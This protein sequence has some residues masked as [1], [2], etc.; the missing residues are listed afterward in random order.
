MLRSI[1]LKE[2]TWL[3]NSRKLIHRCTCLSSKTV[4]K[5]YMAAHW[6]KWCI[7]PIDT[8]QASTATEWT[9]EPKIHSKNRTIC[10]QTSTKKCDLWPSVSVQCSSPSVLNSSQ[11]LQRNKLKEKWMSWR[12]EFYQCSTVNFWVNFISAGTRL[13]VTTFRYTASSIASRFLQ[14]IFC[15][16]LLRNKQT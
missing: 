14:K 1:C 6:S 8:R 7:S 3:R 9:W 15:Q 13:L 10:L 12:T 2:N 5:A 16:A 4:I 11:S